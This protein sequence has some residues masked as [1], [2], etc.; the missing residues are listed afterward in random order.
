MTPLALVAAFA[1]GL[2]L[3]PAVEYL[4]HGVL[5]HRFRTFVTRLHGVHHKEPHRVF[6]SP[7]ASLPVSLAIYAALAWPLGRAPAAAL[8]AGL[9]AGFLRYEWIHWRIHFREPRSARERLLR[10]H[11]LAHHFVNPRAY[12]GVTTRLFDRLLGTLPESW[13]LDYEKASARQALPGASNFRQAY[14]LTTRST[15]VPPPTSTP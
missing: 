13:A 3:W 1:A 14:L 10:A 7:L 11:H 8:V 9:F 15:G 12:H 6:T 4:V 5:S 2:L